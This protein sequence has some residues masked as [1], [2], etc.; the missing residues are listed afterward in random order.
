MGAWKYS[1]PF[2]IWALDRCEW[3]VSFMAQPL[4]LQEKSSWY[5]YQSLDWPQSQPGC[6]GED[7]NCLPLTGIKLQFFS[8][9]ANS[10]VS[11]SAE[12][13]Q[14]HEFSST[15][16]IKHFITKIIQ[17]MMTLQIAVEIHR[18]LSIHLR[19]TD[20]CLSLLVSNT[21]H[22]T[23]V[24]WSLRVYYFVTVFFGR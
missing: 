3:V 4:Y 12:V 1:L 16:H 21:Q 22:I 23:K 2:L 10:W 14:L 13:C 18:R 11:I 19:I 15:G 20:G 9:P 24:R 7:K 17:Y 6:Y 5:T 8:Y